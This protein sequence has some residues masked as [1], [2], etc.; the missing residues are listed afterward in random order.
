MFH[1]ASPHFLWLLPAPS[2][3]L[4]ALG[5][6]PAGAAAPDIGFPKLVAWIGGVAGVWFPIYSLNL[7]IAKMVFLKKS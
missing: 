3:A 5:L 6:A 2:D 7:L 1:Q 4:T